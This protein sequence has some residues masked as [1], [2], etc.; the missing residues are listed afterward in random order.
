M[1]FLHMGTLPYKEKLGKVLFEG[2][3]V[4]HKFSEAKWRQ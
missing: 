1:S 4:S 2:A 3:G